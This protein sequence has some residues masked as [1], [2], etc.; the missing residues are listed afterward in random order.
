MRGVFRAQS[1]AALT[2]PTGL[3]GAHFE[4]VAKTTRG[5]ERDRRALALDER[6]GDE[7]RAVDDLADVCH[8]DAGGSDQFVEP[9][10]RTD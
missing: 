3:F 4:H 1:A 7:R 6:V 8:A 10:E 2:R 9:G 5:E